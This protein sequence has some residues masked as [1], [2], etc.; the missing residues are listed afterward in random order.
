MKLGDAAVT[1]ASFVFGAVLAAVASGCGATLYSLEVGDEVGFE[2]CPSAAALAKL[3]RIEVAVDED[4]DVA[5]ARFEG[6]TG[7]WLRQ[8]VGTDTL[9]G[10]RGLLRLD[11]EVT[12]PRH[13]VH[14]CEV[15]TRAV[16]SLFGPG[17]PQ[18]QLELSQVPVEPTHECSL[19]QTALLLTRR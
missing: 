6:P 17:V 4:G 10:E 1:A 8:H 19:C 16:F 13:R 7:A 18:A 5:V 2:A 14:G 11:A 15:E 12:G 3:E 9:R